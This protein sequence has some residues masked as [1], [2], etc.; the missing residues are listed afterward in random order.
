MTAVAT[1]VEN[2]PILE[3]IEETQSTLAQLT[4]LQDLQKN[5]I[6]RLVE[7]LKALLAYIKEALPLDPTKLGCPYHNIREAY[8]V[9]EAQLVMVD[10][11]AKMLTQHLLNLEPE[12]IITIIEESV[13][14]I[15]RIIA[16]KKQT[17]EE[18]VDLL[19]RLIKEFKKINETL[20]PVENTNL[21]GDAIQKALSET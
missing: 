10:K 16:S 21:S 3:A 2:T 4:E 9:G 18:R 8:L 11:D 17:L 12:K 1:S 15:N 13:P 19:E 5:Y 14:T 6:T 7:D 20:N